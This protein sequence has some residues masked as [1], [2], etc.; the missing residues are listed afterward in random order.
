MLIPESEWSLWNYCIKSSCHGLSQQGVWVPFWTPK[1]LKRTPQDTQLFFCGI[2]KNLNLK[3]LIEFFHL[4]IIP[5]TLSNDIMSY[6]DEFIHVHGWTMSILWSPL[7]IWTPK[8]FTTANFRHPV[9]KSWLRHWFMLLGARQFLSLLKWIG[10]FVL[11]E[12]CILSSNYLTT[13]FSFPAS[14]WGGISTVWQQRNNT[15]FKKFPTCKSGI[16]FSNISSQS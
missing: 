5:K 12:V 2:S 9:S 14:F 7:K 4:L 8:N 3:L 13:S 6:F 16:Q 10:T 15:V 1:P 11:S